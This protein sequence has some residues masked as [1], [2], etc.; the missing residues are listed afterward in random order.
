MTNLLVR[1]ESEVACVLVQ[2]FGE[3]VAEINYAGPLNMHAF[4]HVCSR[5]AF[6]VLCMAACVCVIGTN[7]GRHVEQ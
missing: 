2:D 3:C 4:V 5:E 7:M 1:A 6:P